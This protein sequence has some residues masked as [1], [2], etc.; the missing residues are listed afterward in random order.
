MGGWQDGARQGEWWPPGV[1]MISQEH[2]NNLQAVTYPV[3]ALW[4]LRRDILKG[5]SYLCG[6]L[7]WCSEPSP[8]MLRPD[9]RYFLIRSKF[10]AQNLGVSFCKVGVFFRGQLIHTCELHQDAGKFVLH[11]VR[12]DGHRF[13]GLFEQ[14]G[15]TPNIAALGSSGNRPVIN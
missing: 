1:R 7:V 13:H 10:A 2:Q 9:S 11:V 5:G 12:K 6:G 8:T 15:H 4:R 3:S 14:S